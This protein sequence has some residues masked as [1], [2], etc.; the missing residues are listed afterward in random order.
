M[1]TN[2]NH[3]SLIKKLIAEIRSLKIENENLNQS[4]YFQSEQQAR[5]ERRNQQLRDEA[6]RTERQLQQ[7]RDDQYYKDS[8]RTDLLK[9]LDRAESWGDEYSKKKIKRDLKRL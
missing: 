7:E 5:I 3:H 1:T 4:I 6:D 8:Q 2:M 9:K